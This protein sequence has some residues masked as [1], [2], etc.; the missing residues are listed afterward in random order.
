MAVRP[1]IT[2]RNKKIVEQYNQLFREGF[3]L[4]VIHQRLSE[5]F[6]IGKAQIERVITQS[7]N[8]A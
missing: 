8:E 4:D 5:S 6:H 1:L 7:K 3:R 2:I